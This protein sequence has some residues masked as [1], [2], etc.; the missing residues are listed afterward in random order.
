MNAENIP[1]RVAG[2][3]MQARLVDICGMRVRGLG[4]GKEHEAAAGVFLLKLGDHAEK[5]RRSGLGRALDGLV[6]HVALDPTAADRACQGA[7][8][9]I[10]DRLAVFDLGFAADDG[11]AFFREAGQR[12]WQ[13]LTN[14]T[15][16]HWTQG[17]AEPQHLKEATGSVGMRPKEAFAEVFAQ[18]VRGGL[19]SLSPWTQDFFRGIVQASGSK[20]ARRVLRRYLTSTQVPRQATAPVDLRE[21]EITKDNAEEV[22]QGLV[23]DVDDLEGAEKRLGVN[24][25]NIS[26][27]MRQFQHNDDLHHN[28]ETVMQHTLEVID[29]VREL[30]Q[31][32]D[33]L[34]KQ[35]LGLVA[36]LHDLGKAYTYEWQ[37]DKQKH[38]FY[39]HMER[40]TE[41]AEVLLAK[42]RESLGDLYKRIIDLVR[43]HDMFLVLVNSRAERGENLRYL[44]PLL[45]ETV[46]AEGHIDDLLTLSK[47]DSYRA[48]SYAEK[49]HDVEGVIQDLA[50]YEKKK[51]EDAAREVVEQKRMESALRHKLPEIQALLESEAPYAV[52]ALPDLSKVNGLLGAQKRYDL[53]KRIKSMLS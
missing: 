15:R 13:Q 52:E 14:E 23:S 33:K 42:H 31:D 26:Q 35:L 20:L 25:R 46:Y 11:T 3:F 18:Y 12:F 44:K 47:A 45:K 29:A 36:L 28:G 22:L 5:V 50:A 2:R 24:L 38:T 40:S 10:R 19:S 53:I 1:H 34:Q 7:Y 9:D 39:K 6:V 27:L 32:K 4:L 37:P 21:L 49:L 17:V 16:R 8:E 51:V 41:I 48:K 30:T 43:I